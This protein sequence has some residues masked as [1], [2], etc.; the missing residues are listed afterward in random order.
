MNCEHTDDEDKCVF[1]L[2]AQITDELINMKTQ[3]QITATNCHD[4][5]VKHALIEDCCS[6]IINTKIAMYEASHNK[7]VKS[8]KQILHVL[9]EA[10]E[11][12]HT[13]TKLLRKIK[14]EF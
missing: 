12:S 4:S 5:N 8:L 7:D 2:C 11:E 1:C 13:K 10:R 14:N 3:T 9:A 6:V